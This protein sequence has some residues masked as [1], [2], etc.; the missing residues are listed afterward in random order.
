MTDQ[1]TLLIFV[2]AV[3]IGGIILGTWI[4]TA[5]EKKMTCKEYLMSK[6]KGV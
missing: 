4:N 3:L 1:I 2:V 5:A 6:I